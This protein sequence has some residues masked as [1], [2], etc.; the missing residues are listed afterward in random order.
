[1]EGEHSKR[2]RHIKS[3]V[4]HRRSPSPSLR[5]PSPPP[6]P[7]LGGGFVPT[8]F[9]LLNL[10]PFSSTL[11]PFINLRM[12]HLFVHELRYKVPIV[13]FLSSLYLDHSVL[14]FQLMNNDHALSLEQI[15]AIVG[16]PT[17]NTF[18]LNDPLPGYS[19]LTWWTD[20]THRHPYVSSSAK[21]SSLIHI[22]ASL[23]VPIEERSTISALELKILYAMAHP[24]DNLIPHYDSFLCNKL[25]CLS[26]S[27]SGKIYCGDIVSLFAKSAPVRAPY[28]R[29]HQ[30][31]SGESYLTTVVLESMRMFRTEY[32]NHN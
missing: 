17:K 2:P 6:N 26:T 28:L 16:A 14:Y 30:P 25:T 12:C 20:L 10:R 5:S 22:I 3:S 27:R 15:N 23:V 19:D 1:M 18:G 8:Q 13:E 11:I 32:G 7:T 21:A 9:K 24:D 4:R 29:I 31:L